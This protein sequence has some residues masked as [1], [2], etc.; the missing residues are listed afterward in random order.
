V[1]RGALSERLRTTWRN[2][3]LLLVDRN[4]RLSL[5]ALA[6]GYA[7][8][9]EKGGRTASEPEPGVSR[10]LAEALECMVSVLD[11]QAEAEGG[12]PRGANISYTP[13]GLPYVS[14]NPR[15]Q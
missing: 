3:R 15:V 4:A 2:H 7:L 12:F 8:P 11:R 6:A 9:A 13:G 14:S 10:L 1:A 5:N